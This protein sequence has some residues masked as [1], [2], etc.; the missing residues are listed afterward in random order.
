[1]RLAGVDESTL[2]A[3]RAHSVAV[4]QDSN[5]GLPFLSDLPLL[6]QLDCRPWRCLTCNRQGVHREWTVSFSE[7]RITCPGILRC[8]RTSTGKEELF[9][10]DFL[11][12]SVELFN[13]ARALRR[14]VMHNH[15]AKQLG[16]G[17]SSAG[18]LV[19]GL[20]PQSARAPP[21]PGACLRA[22]QAI[23]LF[24]GSA[25][26]H[27]G[28]WKLAQLISVISACE[29]TGNK[30]YTHPYTVLHGFTG[31]DG[32]SLCPVSPG[33]AEMW[34]D[35]EEKLDAL[36]DEMMTN[37][38]AANLPQEAIAPVC[39]CR[40]TYGK[41]RYTI[42]SFH[43]RDTH[44]HIT[45]VAAHTE[46]RRA[47]GGDS[48]GAG[49]PMHAHFALRRLATPGFQRSRFPRLQLALST[50]HWTSPLKQNR[51]SRQQLSSLPHRLLSFKTRARKTLSPSKL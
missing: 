1:M 28:N 5:Y 34:K 8:R 18:P 25:I 19:H 46:S 24:C 31:L 15:T 44:A 43:A 49:E 2:E 11:L 42:R 37:R 16:N 38:L 26:K 32:A 36:V 3:G 20:G 6:Q 21:Q 9:T 17:R 47:C 22:V 4:R 10:R 45:R 27:D 30:K 14:C 51:S 41:H 12:F 50:C 29:R 7:S 39:H 33:L 48:R 40:D 35:I 13:D 23:H